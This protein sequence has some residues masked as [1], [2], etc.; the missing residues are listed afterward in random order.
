MGIIL[1]DIKF[2]KFTFKTLMNY[3]NKI[4]IFQRSQETTQF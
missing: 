4:I 2:K 3:R 1:R